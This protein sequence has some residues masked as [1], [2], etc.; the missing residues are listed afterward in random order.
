[1]STSLYINNP[2][3]SSGQ[4]NMTQNNTLCS[5]D[6]D[7][8]IQQHCLEIFYF[9]FSWIYFHPI[10]A[11]QNGNIKNQIILK[12]IQYNFCSSVDIIIQQQPIMFWWSRHHDTTSLSPNKIYIFL[13]LFSSHLSQTK[14]QHNK[15]NNFWKIFNVFFVLV[16]TSLYNNNPLCSSGQDNMIQQRH[17]MF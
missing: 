4:D 12:N 5:S 13:N 17:I 8:M 10:W 1:M 6:Q 16:S 7:I 11:R 2:L 3:Y 14:W 9:L 15:S